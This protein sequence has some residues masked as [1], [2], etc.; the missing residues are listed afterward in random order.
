[1]KQI[2]PTFNDYL[3]EGRYDKLTGTFADLIFDKIKETRK[4]WEK[5]KIKNPKL[6]TLDSDIIT[7]PKFDKTLKFKSLL[8]IIRKIGGMP[9]GF[10]IDGFTDIQPE[11]YRE[12]DDIEIDITID[13]NMEPQCY[14]KLNIWL[15]DAIR[16]EVEHLTQ[17][18]DN[19]MQHK[20]FPASQEERE[21][22][23]A[24]NIWK[25]Y[26]LSDE[27]DAMIHGLYKASKLNKTEFDI[28][29][30]DYLNHRK[31][32]GDNIPD[33]KF[34]LIMNTWLSRAKELFSSLKLSN[35][36]Y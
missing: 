17:E 25:Y 7:I 27:I 36:K 34:S 15:Q 22:I 4:K 8:R 19:L 33:D 2:I 35:T 3:F 14:N 20:A 29:A 30:S 13:P 24:K 11:G 5:E 6:K 26:L 9:M 28:T 16:H 23:T 1:M 31:S 21:R 10:I 18:G 12:K 32:L